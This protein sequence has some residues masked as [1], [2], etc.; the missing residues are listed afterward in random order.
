VRD[1]SSV[2]AIDVYRPVMA[3]M[4]LVI[5]LTG[6]ALS[7]LEEDVGPTRV[8]ASPIESSFVHSYCRWLE[9][10]GASEDAKKC[11]M[12]PVPDECRRE[13]ASA[14]I[15]EV[16]QMSCTDGLSVRCEG[17]FAAPM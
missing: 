6:C 3:K 17:C 16:E 12:M 10:C 4:L 5:L 13:L 11:W 1:P 14:C 9:R 15:G 8:D 2:R 7:R